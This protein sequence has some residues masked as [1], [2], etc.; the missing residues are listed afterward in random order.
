MV[1][2]KNRTKIE[3]QTS[4]PDFV[5]NDQVVVLRSLHKFESTGVRVFAF[6]IQLAVV[7]AHTLLIVERDT[8]TVQ[9]TCSEA[10]DW[11]CYCDVGDHVTTK[12]VVLYHVSPSCKEESAS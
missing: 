9:P 12:G 5:V 1:H 11:L 8:P 7:M 2:N 3:W 6:F 10:M 4:Y